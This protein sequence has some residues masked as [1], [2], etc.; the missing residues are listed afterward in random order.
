M[1]D[2]IM[3]FIQFFELESHPK[4]PSKGEGVQLGSYTMKEFCLG[5]NLTLQNRHVR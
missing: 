1:L 5:F 2:D 4:A 3:L